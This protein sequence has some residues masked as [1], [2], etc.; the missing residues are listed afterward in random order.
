MQINMTQSLLSKKPQPTQRLT[1]SNSEEELLDKSGWREQEIPCSDEQKAPCSFLERLSALIFSWIRGNGKITSRKWKVPR[2]VSVFAASCIWPE[3]TEL[4]AAMLIL[5]GAV[6]TH[7]GHH[8]H[9]LYPS[10]CPVCRLQI[11]SCT[12]GGRHALTVSTVNSPQNKACACPDLRGCAVWRDHAVTPSLLCMILLTHLAL[13]DSLQDPLF[14]LMNL[15]STDFPRQVHRANEHLPE[16]STSQEVWRET[17]GTWS[18]ELPIWAQQS[19]PLTI[20][21]S[22]SWCSVCSAV[23]RS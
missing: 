17:Q 22:L 3:W 15:C 5:N 18:L 14:H 9:H 4:S 7:S 19:Q 23:R 21:V 6:R 16:A 11:G 12:L 8:L 10:W 20:V 1:Y 2:P 13:E